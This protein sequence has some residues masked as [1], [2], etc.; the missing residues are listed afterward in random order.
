MAKPK[1]NEEGYQLV[2]DIISKSRLAECLDLTR[3]AVGNWG[4]RVPEAYAYRV[5]IITGVPIEDI[6][7]EVAPEVHRRLKEIAYAKA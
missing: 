1:T 3:Q 5:S 6:L 2:L 7:P 4:P